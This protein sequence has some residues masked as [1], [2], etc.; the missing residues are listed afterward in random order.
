MSVLCCHHVVTTLPAPILLMDTLVYVSLDL[1][2]CK[3]SNRVN[4]VPLMQYLCGIPRK[5]SG[6]L[7]CWGVFQLELVKIV[8]TS[9]LHKK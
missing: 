5:L 6:S 3:Q 9:H 7:I 1:L 4:N 8:L 2:V